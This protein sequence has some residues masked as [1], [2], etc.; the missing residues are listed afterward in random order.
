[1]NPNA[2]IVVRRLRRLRRFMELEGVPSWDGFVPL[3]N[4]ARPSTSVP[5]D[6]DV[7]C[8]PKGGIRDEL[9]SYPGSRHHT[10]YTSEEFHPW[11]AFG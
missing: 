5:M 3:L 2:A 6:R 8:G 10:A 4:G 11:R 7:I 1:M 9:G